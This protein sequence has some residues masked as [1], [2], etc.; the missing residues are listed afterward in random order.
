MFFPESQRVIYEKNPL[1]EVICQLRFPT[2]L[3]ID[4]GP[5]ADFQ[6]RIREKY[7]LYSVQEP[8]IEYPKLP[9]EFS[10]ILE[11]GMPKP[12]GS[13][14]HRFSTKDSKRFISLAQ[15][16][17]AL[18]ESNYERWESFRGELVEAEKALTELYRPAFYSRI[19][20]RY[21]DVISR[22]EL[23]MSGAKW[24]DLLQPHIVGELGESGVCDAII[25]TQTRS[26]I[27]IP[28][29]PGGQ[30]NLIHGLVRPSETREECYLIDADFS[31]EQTEGL[32]E[33]FEILDKFNRLGRRLFRWAI[34][35]TL[36]GAM[37]PKK[38]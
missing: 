3:R 32:N 37:G 22:Q 25:T 10:A 7:P 9:K 23:G 29:L 36:H 12:P 2:I 16:F 19:G 11:L 21:K 13:T 15:N 30:V 8:N 17:L 18:M 20:L 6:D 28:E 5:L 26:V 4:A 14:T 35:D 31:I 27:R 1:I 33:P 24:K 34:T 38:I